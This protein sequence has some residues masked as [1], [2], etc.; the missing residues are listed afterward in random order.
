[1]LRQ[2]NQCQHNNKWS[3][4]MLEIP[5]QQLSESTSHQTLL[6]FIASNRQ[7]IQSSDWFKW[8]CSFC[9][10]K[11]HFVCSDRWVVDWSLLALHNYPTMPYLC[12]RARRGTWIVLRET[13]CRWW[14]KRPTGRSRM[15]TCS[16]PISSGE[17]HRSR[18]WRQIRRHRHWR[19]YPHPSHW[20]FSHWSCSWFLDKLRPGD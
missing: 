1:M 12:C 18:H 7:T 5:W 8:R 4:R 6:V 16:S 17:G 13:R 2:E 9:R 3:A 11:H 14:W 20:K 19:R 15:A 10:T